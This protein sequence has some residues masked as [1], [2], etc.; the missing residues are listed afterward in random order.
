MATRSATPALRGASRR[1]D[2]PGRE[3]RSALRSA[4]ASRRCTQWPPRS[5][6]LPGVAAAPPRTDRPRRT[7][8]HQ[9]AQLAIA[10]HQNHG[11]PL[12]RTAREPQEVGAGYWRFASG[13]SKRRRSCDEHD[14]PR[15]RPCWRLRPLCTARDLRPIDAAQSP[16]QDANSHCGHCGRRRDP[17]GRVV[18]VPPITVPYSSPVSGLARARVSGPPGSPCRA[19]SRTGSITVVHAART[20]PHTRRIGTLS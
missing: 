8:R 7:H 9:P 4:Y 17:G 6:D 16:G 3:S 13:R 18:Y 14:L 11:Y 1:R 2:R 10:P 12:T 19:P 20:R 5:A 15:V